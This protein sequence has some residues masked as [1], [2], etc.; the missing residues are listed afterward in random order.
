MKRR[1]F[2][3]GATGALAVGASGCAN[4]EGLTS[5]QWPE[6]LPEEMQ[7]YIANLDAAM[8]RIAYAQ[9][10]GVFSSAFTRRPREGDTLLFRKSMRSLL[11]VG[12]FGDLSIAGQVHPGVQKRMKYSTP[13]MTGAVMD[14]VQKMASMSTDER[15]TLKNAL[16]EKPE[17]VERIVEA[18]DYEAVAVG[19]PLRR[20]MQLRVMSRRILRR[21]KQSPD[22]FIDEY[23][24]KAK[25][26]MSQPVADDDMERIMVARIGS[27]AFE[28]RIKEAE[29]AMLHWQQLGVEDVPIGYDLLLDDDETDEPSDA[30][31]RKGLKS[32]GLGLKITLIGGALIGLGALLNETP[33][34]LVPGVILGVTVGPIIL[35]VGLI[36]VILGAFID[37]FDGP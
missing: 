33:I 24:T 18:I 30:W 16:R 2:V 23:V 9:G 8:N 3:A 27:E 14:V 26:I 22:L 13:E 11:L 36:T 19:A 31:Y 32:L 12:N 29:T 20:R 28:K 15:T 5:S 34:F 4:L 21:M 25:K 6:L 37:A 7:S 35:V 1:N 17:L 10:T